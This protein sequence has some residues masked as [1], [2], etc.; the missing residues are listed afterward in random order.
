MTAT[1][2]N[3]RI[4]KAC[5][6]ERADCTPVWFMRQAGRYMPEYREIRSRCG[7]M[8][9]FKNPEIA[10]EVTLQPLKA[11]QVDAAILFA[12]ILLPLEGMGVQIEFAEGEGPVIHNPVRTRA[13]AEALRVGDPEEHLGY[14]MKT[15]RLVRTELKPDVALIGFG[16]APF[17]IASYLIE[18]GGS[19][20]YVATKVLMYSD[21]GTWALVMEKITETLRQYL[22]AQGRAGA[23]VIQIFD[24][25]AGCLGPQDYRE[26]VFPYASKLLRSLKEA[27]IPTI[28]FGTGTADLLPLLREAGG[29][30]IGVDWRTPLDVAWSRIGGGVGVQGNLDPVTLLAPWP[31]LEARAREVLDSVNDRPGHIFN[32]G[33]GILPNTP[34]DAVKRLA[35]FVHYF[36]VGPR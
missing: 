16:G 22:I 36:G 35:D 18:G 32:L 26:F 27:G 4:I 31:L 10:A 17:T 3:S 30:V 2:S 6:R 23:Q 14:V 34:V 9:M 5:R 24:S 1:D 15:L 28:H 33:H 25:W 21:P 19:R 8:E 7:L 12:D 20:N 11:L 13:D 29:D